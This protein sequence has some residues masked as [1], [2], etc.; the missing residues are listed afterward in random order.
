MAH[1][2]CKETPLLLLRETFAEMAE[3]EGISEGERWEIEM[4]T[5]VAVRRVGYWP[6]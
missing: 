5:D 2:C 4:P 3:N 6:A 1:A